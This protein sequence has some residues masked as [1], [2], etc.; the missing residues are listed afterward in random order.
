MG[1]DAD[2]KEWGDEGGSWLKEVRPK[3][4][5]AGASL[6]GQELFPERKWA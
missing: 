5:Q 2:S 1:K 6:E 3:E 4:R